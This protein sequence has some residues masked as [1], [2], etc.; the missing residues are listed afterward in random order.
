MLPQITEVLALWLSW[1]HCRGSSVGLCQLAPQ[2]VELYISV[3]LLVAW[4]VEVFTGLP[5]DRTLSDAVANFSGIVRHGT[6]SFELV[7]MTF[8]C[9]K[10]ESPIVLV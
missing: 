9:G 1:G 8:V 10:P 5:S 3:Q 2:F 6:W 7:A 4:C